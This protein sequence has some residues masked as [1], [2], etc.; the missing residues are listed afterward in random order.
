MELV[1]SAWK[2]LKSRRS[3]PQAAGR[4]VL[5]RTTFDSIPGPIVDA[6]AVSGLAKGILGEAWNRFSTPGFGSRFRLKLLHCTYTIV[7]ILSNRNKTKGL[8]RNFAF[9]SRARSRPQ[10]ISSRTPRHFL[11]ALRG[12][13]L[14]IFVESVP[15]RTKAFNREVREGRA[16][17]GAKKIHAA[18][19]ALQ[20]PAI[21]L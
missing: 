10:W 3:I 14:L 11:C 7:H 13:R 20:N 5:P 12:E 4:A 17:K 2:S 8:R 19:S 21:P 6:R 18:P 1:D 15:Q 9:R 16:A